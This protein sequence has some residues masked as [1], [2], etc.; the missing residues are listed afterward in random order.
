[1][2]AEEKTNNACEGIINEILSDLEKNVPVDKD[3]L[4]A[5]HP[6]CAQ[7]IHSVIDIWRELDLI[8]VPNRSEDRNDRFFKMLSDFEDREKSKFFQPQVVL[9]WAAVLILGIFL[10]IL[11]SRDGNDVVNVA[12]R[13]EDPL[14][15][16][17]VSSSTTQRLQALQSIKNME[18]PKEAM[19]EALYQT[20]INDPNVNVRLSTVEALI[21]FADEPLVR[22]LMIKALA[23]QDSP[24]VQLMLADIIMKFQEE[25]TTQKLIEI[26][27]KGDHLDS[28]V[29]LFM[30]ENLNIL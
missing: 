13:G 8:Q 3:R 30:K 28:E 18:K 15:H 17:L 22:S 12:T 23:N 7:E 14:I 2:K 21:H 24:I 11:I 9:K 5:E 29:K 20:L 26:I 25:G 19:Y 27:D 16:S 1:M 4:I 6:D 10:G